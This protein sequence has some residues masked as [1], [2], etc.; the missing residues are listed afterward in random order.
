[1][2]LLRVNHEQ[3][4]HH[5]HSSLPRV[6]KFDSHSDVLS[7]ARPRF[8][9]QCK[10]AD[11]HCVHQT[12]PGSFTCRLVIRWSGGILPRTSMAPPSPVAGLSPIVSA[13]TE[14]DSLSAS[15]MIC[16]AKVSYAADHHFYQVLAADGIGGPLACRC[17]WSMVNRDS[18]DGIW[19]LHRSSGHS[20]WPERT[21]NLLF[22][23]AAAI[24]PCQE[25][26]ANR[27]F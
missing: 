17:S 1:M 9:S 7:Q 27:P 10:Q 15:S 19:G 3:V 23:C 26:R 22:C 2:L 18:E 16:P 13:S 12:I 21:G 20:Q 24:P 11:M 8:L 5:G 14:V 25:A 6:G 4:C